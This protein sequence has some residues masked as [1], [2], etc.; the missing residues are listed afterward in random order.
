ML[1]GS[2]R[3]AVGLFPSYRNSRQVWIF[4]LLVNTDAVLFTQ[5]PRYLR[6]FPAHIRVIAIALPNGP[7][8]NGEA[9][10]RALAYGTRQRICSG[11]SDVLKEFAHAISEHV[12]TFLS[13]RIESDKL[14][15][16]QIKRQFP[17]D[18]G[19]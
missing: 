10:L 17:P 8:T 7:W 15:F 3:I 9:V 4:S 19:A 18:L 14:L 12:S 5:Q 2:C 6:L 11:C 1:L 16:V 13:S